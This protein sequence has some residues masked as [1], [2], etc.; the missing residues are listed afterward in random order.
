MQHRTSQQLLTLSE[1]YNN[2]KRKVFNFDLKTSIDSALL[3]WLGRELQSFGASTENALS[4]CW[5]W[6]H[7][8]SSD[9]KILGTGLVDSDAVVEICKRVLDHGELCDYSFP[10]R[11]SSLQTEDATELF[12]L[13]ALFRASN[14]LFHFVFIFHVPKAPPNRKQVNASHRLASCSATYL[15]CICTFSTFM[16][17]DASLSPFGLPPQVN[18]SQT[19]MDLHWLVSRFGK[20]L[21]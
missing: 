2:V 18:A 6:A 19:C 21:Q 14:T 15:H 11:Q 10:D 4:P 5:S 9:L 7:A 8:T 12:Y 1:N 17:V 3:I 20:G 16:H 13:W